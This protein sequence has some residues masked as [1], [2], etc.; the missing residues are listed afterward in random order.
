MDDL[1]RRE[2]VAAWMT[3]N[4]FAT[5]HGDTLADLLRELTWQVKE[6]R[7]LAHDFERGVRFVLERSETY[8]LGTVASPALQFGDYT[9]AMVPKPANELLPGSA[10]HREKRVQAM[11]ACA[12]LEIVK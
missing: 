3:E 10:E 7:V 1:E 8:T 2:L 6:L 12:A 9:F 5:G 4:G 11:L